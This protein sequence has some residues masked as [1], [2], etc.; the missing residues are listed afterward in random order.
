[1]MSRYASEHYDDA[2]L[3]AFRVIEE[4]LRDALGKSDAP[5]K[6]L[7]HAGFNPATGTL[8]DP[9]AWQS[10][11]EGM[12]SLFKSAFQVFRDRRA[13]GFVPTDA[14]EAFDSIVLANRLLLIVEARVSSSQPA[15]T[16]TYP[17]SPDKLMSLLG[18]HIGHRAEPVL[19]DADGDGEPELVSPGSGEEGEV[20]TIF[21]EVGGVR[22]RADV[23]RSPH[24]DSATLVVMNISNADVDNDGQQ[25][26]V[27]TIEAGNQPWALMF[28]KYRNG[29]YE[30][31]RG[32]PRKIPKYGGWKWH[33]EE[34]W[35]RA[36]VG[37]I[38]EDGKV[39]IVSE[40]KTGGAMPPPVRY[41]WKWNE[42]EGGFQLLYEEELTYSFPMEGGK[43][44]VED[45]R[46]AP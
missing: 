38:D 36:F 4:T 17:I 11:R 9:K 14:E 16:T 19:L 2:V 24:Y 26:V 6:D 1:V 40:P 39:E 43:K 33:R 46:G 31:L 10:E 28:F 34:I 41:I 20:I 15:P 12:F 21:K 45:P 27:C 22:R 8:Q 5:M 25:E 18:A 44:Q 3:A 23:E 42:N 30:I 37:D 13:H 29:R 35:L 7:L 32:I